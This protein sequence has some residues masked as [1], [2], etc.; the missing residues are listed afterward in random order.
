MTHTHEIWD[1]LP[2]LLRES[3]P[4]RIA[5]IHRAD[6]ALDVAA[7][8]ALLSPDVEFRIGAGPALR[9][10]DA[11]RAAV[12]GLFAQ[13]RRGLVHEVRRAWGEGQ[14]LV[15]EAEVTFPLKDGRDLV[16]PNVN[17]IDFDGHGLMSRYAICMDLSPFAAPA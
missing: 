2:G 1:R 13:V 16:S 9:G 10:R 17:V 11:V 5:A 3:A 8:V 12:A 7:F 4:A 6:A 15:Y 14:T